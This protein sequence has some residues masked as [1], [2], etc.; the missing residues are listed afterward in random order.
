MD[1]RL[2]KEFQQSLNEMEAHA[3]GKKLKGV[4]EVV[5]EVKAPKPLSR[6]E[7]INIRKRL[8]VSQS[9]FALLLNI[10]KK[11][12]QKWEQ[13]E[14]RPNGSSLKLLT[15]AKKDPKTLYVS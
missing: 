3:V 10:S 1:K 9:A 6:E 11:T 7:I 5:K 8:Q 2:F 15:I 4:R 14:N 13:G 12:V